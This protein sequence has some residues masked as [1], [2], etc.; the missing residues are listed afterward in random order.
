MSRR[1]PAAFPLDDARVYDHY[2]A[3]RRSAALAAG[4]R[5]GLFDALA[6]A[7]LTEAE[8]AARCGWRPRPTRSLL[9]ALQAMGVIVRNG[10]ALT[11]A[12]DAAAYLVRGK[13][14]SLWGLIDMEMEAFLS[15]QALL[16]ALTTG[17]T[18]VYGDEDPWARHA[19]DPAR[20]RAFTAAMHSI[21]ER[22]AAGFAEVAPL[23]EAR[24]LLD[25]GGGSG[26]LSL[27][28]ARAF[29][30]LTCTVLDLPGVC[31]IAAEY[32]AAAGLGRRVQTFPADMFADPWPAADAVLLSQILH[33]WPPARG[34]ELL[35]K[36]LATLPPGGAVLIHE[37]LVD[38]DGNG[39]LAN[40]LVHLDMLVWTEGQQYSE[41]ELRTMLGEAGFV[42]VTRQATAGAWSLVVGRVPA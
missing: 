2:I 37:K 11:L 42:G 36:A 29:A 24:T 8:V 34:R 10:E 22:P 13:A 26:A 17:K 40:A 20:A 6:A 23:G 21:S 27:A 38:D 7:P 9:A 31:A 14:G 4:V 19:R 39:P 28:A 32:A 35:G 18:S 1:S 33:D 25:V 41:G 12:P 16:E 15:P 5:A 3:G 30:H